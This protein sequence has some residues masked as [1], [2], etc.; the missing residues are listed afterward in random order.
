ML[1]KC[2]IV[3]AVCLLLA[4]PAR[5]QDAPQ[6]PPAVGDIV[7][8]GIVGK[9]LDA[10]PM[11]PDERVIL[12]RTNAVVSGTL[13]GRSLMVWAGL[14]NPILIVAGLAWGVYSAFNIKAAEANGKPGTNRVEPLD[15][16]K[17]EQPQIA[18]LTGPPLEETTEAAR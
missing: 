10:M 14:T 2:S 4:I 6:P 11:D 5:A 13:T 18:L 9:A 15:P 16:I 7:Y 8:K 1:I 12:Q 3:L 17:A